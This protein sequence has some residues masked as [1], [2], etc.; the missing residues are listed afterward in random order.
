MN[1]YNSFWGTTRRP[2]ETSNGNHTPILVQLSDPAGVRLGDVKTDHPRSVR[3]TGT[4]FT[5]TRPPPGLTQAFLPF[6]LRTRVTLGNPEQ[7]Q[8]VQRKEVYAA[9]HRLRPENAL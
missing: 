3:F 2:G 6:R 9:S 4:G 5:K 7:P 8:A 1:G